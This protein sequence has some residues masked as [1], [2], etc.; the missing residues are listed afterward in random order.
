MDSKSG[1]VASVGVVLRGDGVLRGVNECVASLDD[2]GGVVAPPR[3]LLVL[4]L[5]GPTVLFFIRW[6]YS[7][8]ET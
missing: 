5:V 3:P 1:S 7:R 4:L 8:R 6:R 2:T